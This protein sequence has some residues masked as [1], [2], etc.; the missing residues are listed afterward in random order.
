MFCAPPS[1]CSSST[2]CVTNVNSAPR[3]AR[4]CSI[5]ASAM[6]PGFGRA[7]STMR[8]RMRYQSVTSAGSRANASGVARSSARK[9]RHSAAAPL[10]NVGMPLSAEI[11]A[12]VNAAARRAR[13]KR[14]AI[15]P[16][17]ARCRS[18][19][20]MAAHKG[21]HHRVFQLRGWASDARPNTIPADHKRRHHR[22]CQF[23]GRASDARPNTIPADHKGRHHRACQLRGWASDARP[24]TI[25][26]GHKGRH[27]S[28]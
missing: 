1:A 16:A 2:F 4:R 7:C 14:A 24:N 25:P 19:S 26:A 28:G 15:S 10:R 5:C 12:P 3:A 9:L 23:R 21:R 27:Y 22:A 6:C 17:A 8:K 20:L 18:S 13:D 11:P